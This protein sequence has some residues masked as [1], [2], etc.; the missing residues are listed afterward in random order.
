MVTVVGVLGDSLTSTVR[1]ISLTTH[2]WQ[3]TDVA[4]SIASPILP[5]NA[6]AIAFPLFLESLNGM[7]CV[8]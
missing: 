3:H 5:T 8:I 4:A 7:M 2:S 1:I 6:A